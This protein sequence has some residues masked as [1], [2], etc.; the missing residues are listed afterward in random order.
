MHMNP[1]GSDNP[2][3]VCWLSGA[4]RY[5]PDTRELQRK[6]SDLQLRPRM[7]EADRLDNNSLLRYDASYGRVC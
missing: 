5:T 6:A 1:D 3:I 7:G 2:V 4:N